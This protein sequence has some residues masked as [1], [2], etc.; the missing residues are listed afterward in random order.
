[1]WKSG[2]LPTSYSGGRLSASWRSGQRRCVG[3]GA[4]CEGLCLSTRDGHSSFPVDGAWKVWHWQC[5]WCSCLGFGKRILCENSCRIL[6]ERKRE[7]DK[8]KTNSCHLLIKEEIRADFCLI[9]KNYGHRMRVCLTWMTYIHTSST[10][11][12]FLFF[13]LFSATTTLLSSSSLS[14][15]FFVLSPITFDISLSLSLSCSLSSCIN[16]P[17]LNIFP[18]SPAILINNP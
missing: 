16:S 14:W 6:R 15:L 18:W 12:S 1:M 5:V 9:L 11:S 3:R 17:S 2:N 10:P 13:F 7:T 8:V 4:D